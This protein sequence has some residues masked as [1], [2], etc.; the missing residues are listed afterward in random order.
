MKV[1]FNRKYHIGK[2]FEADD[3]GDLPYNL[4]ARLI[5][6]GIVHPAPKPKRKKKKVESKATKAKKESGLTQSK[7]KAG[8]YS[9]YTRQDSAKV[10]KPGD[11]GSLQQ[12]SGNRV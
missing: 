9:G 12:D 8:G 1:I 3:K 2:W 11:S 5:N 10:D 7:T 6:K 4:A